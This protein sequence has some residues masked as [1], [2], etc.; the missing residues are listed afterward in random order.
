MSRLLFPDQG[1]CVNLHAAKQRLKFTNN[2]ICKLGAMSKLLPSTQCIKSYLLI[3]GPLITIGC[4]F[5]LSL[6]CAGED[7][8]DMKSVALETITFGGKNFI[9]LFGI[10]YMTRSRMDIIERVIVSS[11]DSS[12]VSGVSLDSHSSWKSV[13]SSVL[14]FT[15]LETM[16]YNTALWLGLIQ[17]SSLRTFSS[18]VMGGVSC[19]SCYGSFIITSFIVEVIFDFFHYWSHRL[20]HLQPVL[21]RSLHSL[22]HHNSNPTVYHTFNDSICGTILTNPIPHLLAL[23]LLSAILRR[24]ITHIEHSLLLVYKTF[25]EVSGHSGKELGKASSFPQCK[26]L[27]TLVGIELY[28]FDHHSHHRNA[29]TNFSKRFVLWDKVFGTYL[30]PQKSVKFVEINQK[31]LPT[32]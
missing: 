15:F 8:S 32:K 9:L 25:V 27:P 5:H 2:F 19:F 1:E 10:D 16:T 31:V 4:L 24:P 11:S 22:H 28:T 26:W 7:S 17:L 18:S 14:A 12:V 3:N 30:S 20:L 6:L 29:K 13:I 21:Y 23:F